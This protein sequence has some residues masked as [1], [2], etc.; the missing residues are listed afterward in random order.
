MSGLRSRGRRG[1]CANAAAQA[2]ACWRYA[3][4]IGVREPPPSTGSRRRRRCSSTRRERRSGFLRGIGAAGLAN[5]ST[6]PFDHTA[7]KPKPSLRQRFRNLTSPAR[8]FS[9]DERRAG[10]PNFVACGGAIDPLQDEFKIEGQLE[11]ADR[12]DM[13]IVVPQRQQ[14][15]ASDFT[16]D[17]EAEPFEEGLDRPIEQCL[18]YRSPGSFQLKQASG[19]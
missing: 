14:I 10:E 15:A 19:V 13:S 18:Q 2:R 12:H 8:P 16:L 9:R 3:V 17:N 4:M 1:P 11:F 5:M 6:S 7:S